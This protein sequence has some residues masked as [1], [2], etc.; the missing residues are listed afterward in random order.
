MNRPIFFLDADD[1]MGN[2]AIGTIVDMASAAR[3]L[4]AECREALGRLKR[5]DDGDVINLRL[6]RCD[7]SE[8]ELVALPEE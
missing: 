5:G 2:R 7:M 4:G 1:D 8:E 6:S 3:N